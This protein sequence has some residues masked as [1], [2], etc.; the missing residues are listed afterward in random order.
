MNLNQITL[1]STNVAQSI[2]FYENM[3]FNLIVK[4]LPEYARFEATEGNSTF[5]IHKMDALPKEDGIWVYFECSNL[6]KQVHDLISKG[7]SFEGLPQDQPWLW[8]EASLRD[9]DNNKIILYF[10]GENRL[11][12][13]W[14]V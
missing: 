1:P 14:K 12:P 7:F 13:P 11:N 10:A 8:R 9:P 2:E 3:G 6:E 5:S 4:S